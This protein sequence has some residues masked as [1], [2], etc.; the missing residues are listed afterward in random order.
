[1]VLASTSHLD[2]TTI[3]GPKSVQIERPDN[4]LKLDN[5][6]VPFIFPRAN[7]LARQRFLRVWK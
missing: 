6:K 1:M 4:G 5:N 7:P 3:V 2:K